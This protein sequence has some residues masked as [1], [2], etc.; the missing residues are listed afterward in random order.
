MRMRSAVARIVR[1]AGLASA[2]ALAAV[3]GS[4]AAPSS[5]DAQPARESLYRCAAG[6]PVVEVA[7]LGLDLCDAE[8]TTLLARRAEPDNLQTRE[9]ALVVEVEDDGI[10]SGAGVQPGD[11]IYRVAGV[12]VAGAEDAGAGLASV[13]TDSDTQIN[14]LRRG[15]PYRIKLRR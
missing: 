1:A 3:A 8:P 11:M 5:S 10:A 7:T 14:F 4:A 6:E 12:D 13:G 2:L 15:R 9:G